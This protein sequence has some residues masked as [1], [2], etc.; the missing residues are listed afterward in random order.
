MKMSRR[1]S[2]RFYA[3]AVAGLSFAA[4][5]PLR[6]ASLT[7]QPI[8]DGL[9]ATALPNLPALPLR[10]DG[11][12]IE[13]A[14][15]GVGAISGVIWRTKGTPDIEVDYRKMKI[16]L[17]ANG[18]AKLSGT[19]TFGDLEKLPRRSQITLLQCAAT[20]PRG[21]VKWS[22]VRFSDFAGL[23]GVQP[24]A[25][26]VRF[27]GSDAYAV[28]KDIKT[29]MH[30]QVLLAWLLSDRPIPPQHGAPLRLIIPFRYAARSLKAITEIQF[31][32]TTFP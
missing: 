17:A 21:I 31:T 7:A 30:P 22:G 10:P 16:K 3:T 26:Y 27:V 15:T 32:A 11:S 25:A 28:D 6:P 23:I 20:D 8:S 13:Y 19:L 18:T 29:L 2:I 4:I 24:S 14:P 9:S 1:D 12:A 5:G